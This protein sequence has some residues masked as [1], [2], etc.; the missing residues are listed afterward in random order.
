MNNPSSMDDDLNFPPMV[1]AR[2]AEA[3]RDVPLDAMAERF[4]KSRLLT[5]VRD[6]ER[7]ANTSTVRPGDGEWEK[8]SPRIKMKVLRREADSSS[9]SYLLK[10][11]PGAFLVPHHH[12]HDEECVVLE[13]EVTIGE[14]RV[15]PGTYHLAPRGMIHEPI[16]SEH[17]AV[18]FIRGQEPSWRDTAVRETLRA[19]LR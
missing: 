15:G 19:L 9:M 3:I 13:G 16:R 7:G 6:H 1:T 8:F 17:G 14:L 2:M 18:L 12:H 11:E 10:L 4:M 5:R